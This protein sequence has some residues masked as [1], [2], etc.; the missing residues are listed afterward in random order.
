M[1]N[2]RIY[3]LTLPL[4]AIAILLSPGMAQAHLVT[5]GLGPVYD[6][7]GHLVLTVDDLIPVIA[8]A[9]LAG[10]RGPKPGR[11]ALFTLPLAWF[12]GGLFGLHAPREVIFPFQCAS[13]LVLGILVAANVPLPPLLIT[14]LAILLGLSHGYADGSAIKDV[15]MAAGVLELIGL[16]VSL[17]VMVSLLSAL[18]IWLRWEW[19]RIAVRVA[20]SWIAAMGLLI[21]GWSL[22]TSGAI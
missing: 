10:Q 19:S 17:F 11:L 14:F 16:M 21:L 13:F 2:A 18:V 7:I 8:V 4:I 1:L 3:R 22:R 6:G 20:G 5:T 12:L 15:G 9:L